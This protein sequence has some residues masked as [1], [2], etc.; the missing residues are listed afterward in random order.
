[1]Y[2]RHFDDTYP[3]IRLADRLSLLK[4][5]VKPGQQR[6]H[7]LDNFVMMMMSRKITT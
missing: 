4:N 3:R 7:L 6:S 5:D 2:S 1:M